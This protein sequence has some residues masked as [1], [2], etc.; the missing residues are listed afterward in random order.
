MVLGQ[1]R[2]LFLRSHLAC[3]E[4]QGLSPVRLGWPASD[5]SVSV[6]WVGVITGSPSLVF[7]KRELY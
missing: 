3:F 7:A 1:L 2:M 5:P 6:F 4:K